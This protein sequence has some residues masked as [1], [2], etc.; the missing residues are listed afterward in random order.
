MMKST[1][2]HAEDKTTRQRRQSAG[3]EADLQTSE[4]RDQQQDALSQRI[5]ASP[6]MAAQRKVIE[7]MGSAPE[8]IQRQ[9]APEEEEELMQGKFT[10]QLQG[11]EEEEE[12]LQGAFEAG[13]QRSKT[14]DTNR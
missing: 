3:A 12:P 11:P 14:S 6:V 7:R 10:A 2:E 1:L 5:A 4:A 8:L 9:S 13:A